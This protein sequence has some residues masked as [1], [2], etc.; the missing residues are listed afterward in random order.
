MS[1]QKKHSI[2]EVVRTGQALRFGAGR[3][4]FCTIYYHDE[5]KDY[6]QIESGYGTQ[7][8]ANKMDYYFHCRNFKLNKK[9][10]RISWDF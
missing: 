5:M 1:F 4:G 10:F 2:T 8:D 3:Q 7:G 9:G 6:P